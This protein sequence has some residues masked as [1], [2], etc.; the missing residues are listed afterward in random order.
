[1]VIGICKLA[2]LESVWCSKLRVN[3]FKVYVCFLCYITNYHRLSSLKQ[4]PFIVSQF[5]LI[6]SSGGHSSVGFSAQ[7]LTGLQ[8]GCRLGWAVFHSGA[9]GPLLLAQFSSQ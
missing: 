5:V 3:A 4:H 9:W 2:K 8:S 7:G 1:M 6:R